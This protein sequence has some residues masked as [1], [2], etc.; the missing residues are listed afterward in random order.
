[1][2]HFGNKDFRSKDLGNKGKVKICVDTRENELV[3]NRLEE[4]GATVTRALL[5]VADFV[6]SHRTAVE[7][8]TRSDFEASIIDGRL[9][10]QA[11]QLLHSYERV[12]LLVEGGELGGRIDRSALLGAYASLITD[13]GISLFFTSSP[14]STAELLYAIA[15]HEQLSK[16]VPL[17]IKARRRA[18]TLEEELKAIVESLPLV[19]P[20]I[21][22]NL[23]AHF[24]SVENIVMASEKKLMEVELVGKKKANIIKKVLTHVYEGE[25]ER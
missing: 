13:Y 15:K 9:F 23:L 11:K 10:S 3:G 21:A 5:P 1:M 18:L 2:V 6:L 16:R 24:G 8:K 20:S 19:G 4:L 17:R 25:N 14:S 22:T 7:R 12:I